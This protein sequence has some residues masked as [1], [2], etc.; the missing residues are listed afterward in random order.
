ML[1][2]EMPRRM[3]AFEILCGEILSI[4]AASFRELAFSNLITSEIASLFQRL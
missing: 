1:R 3:R 4:A 2:T